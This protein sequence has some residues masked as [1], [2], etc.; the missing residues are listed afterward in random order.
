MNGPLDPLAPDVVDELLSADL[1]GDFAAAARDHGLDVATARARLAATAGVDARR[2][3]LEAAQRSL[4]TPLAP[5]GTDTRHA[6]LAAA[7]AGAEGRVDELARRRERR[8]PARLGGIA[9][10][11][12]ALLVVVGLAVSIATTGSGDDDDSSAAGGAASDTSAATSDDALT[13]APESAAPPAAF[14][15]DFGAI[16]DAAGLRA[17]VEAALAADSPAAGGADGDQS[18]RRATTAGCAT[19]HATALGIGPEVTPVLSGP[20]EYQ[21][22][23]A[24]VYVYLRDG[25]RVIFVFARD[26]CR[27]LVSQVLL[28]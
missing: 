26:D 18:Q 19:L 2:A 15:R 1:D 12:A 24:D 3:Q 10:A 25:E 28:P 5:L 8:W 9:A 6:L 17:A 21:D 11:A 13:A 16:D 7:H 14:A 4:S 22:T 23:P 27:V 20:V